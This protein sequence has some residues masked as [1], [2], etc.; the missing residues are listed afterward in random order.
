MIDFDGIIYLAIARQLV[1]TGNVKMSY[2]FVCTSVCTRT[3]AKSAP[4]SKET[5]AHCLETLGS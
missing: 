1:G 5:A 4:R 2:T 3:E